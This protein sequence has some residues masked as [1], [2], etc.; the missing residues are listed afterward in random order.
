MVIQSDPNREMLLLA[1]THLGSLL[2]EVA[3]LGGAAVG[4]LLTDPGA[5]P[6]RGTFDLDVIIEISSY[7]EYLLLEERMRALGFRQSPE[8]AIVCRWRVNHLVIDVMPTNEQILGF[9]NR[10][11]GPALRNAEWV[12][13]GS[14]RVR[15]VTAPFFL[16][17]KLEAFR[18]RG[19]GDYLGSRDMEDIIA[20]VDGRPELAGEVQISDPELRSYLHAEFLNLLST[21]GFVEAIPGHLLPDGASQQRRAQIIERL[22]EIVD[23]EP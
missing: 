11:Y 18:G 20:L 4:L 1:I 10:W 16:A 21:T 17:T 5:A 19:Q 7:P 23:S 15:V 2:D 6:V 14:Q 22:R 12:N 8:D 9:G 3:L 13:I